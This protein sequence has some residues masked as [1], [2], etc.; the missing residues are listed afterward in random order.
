M[1]EQGKPVSVVMVDIDHFKAVNDTYG[2][3]AGDEVLRATAQRILANIRS[4]DMAARLGGEEFVVVMPDTPQEDA[5]AAAERLRARISETPIATIGG[6]PIA[7][8][9]SLGVAASVRGDSSAVLLKRCDQALYGAKRDGRNRV[10]PGLAIE[11]AAAE[12][13]AKAFAASI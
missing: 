5:M 7:V 1:H 3:D 13:A 11:A 9:A 12:R 2:H 4:F 10:M 8:T 6:R